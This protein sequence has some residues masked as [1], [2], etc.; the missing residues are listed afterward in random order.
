MTRIKI[1]DYV[2]G[3][4]YKDGDPQKPWAVGFIRSIYISDIPNEYTVEWR[5]KNN[6]L[7]SERFFKVKKITQEQG[8]F[9]VDT[10]DSIWM[11]T[12]GKS[13]WWLLKHFEDE[14]TKMFFG[15]KDK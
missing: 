6:I 10:K 1:G 2:V 12:C 13:I 5:D 7:R 11:Q 15:I 8:K 9:L 14:D 3:C 4:K